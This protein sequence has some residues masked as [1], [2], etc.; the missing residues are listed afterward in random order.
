MEITPGQHRF[1]RMM[2]PE[3]FSNY[4]NFLI[5]LIPKAHEIALA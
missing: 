4:L 2:G 5:R 1:T 3:G